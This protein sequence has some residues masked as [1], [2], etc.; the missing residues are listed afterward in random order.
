M[1]LQAEADLTGRFDFY[2]NALYIREQRLCVVSDIHIGLEE[3][4]YAD[5]L[6]FPLHEGETLLDRF[7]SILDRF[8]PRTVVLDGDIFH[9]FDRIARSVQRKFSMIVKTLS[10]ECEVIYVRGSHD[11]MLPSVMGGSVERYDAGG[12]TVIHGDKAVADHG[13]LVMGH[14]HPVVE[15]EMERFPCFLYGRG[16]VNGKDLLMM[17]AFNPLSPGVIINYAKGRDFLSPLLRRVDT[18]RLQPVVEVDGEAVVFPP[19]A[20]MRRLM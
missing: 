12:F 19:L 7:A 15:I 3:A 1:N 2:K 17:P 9:S 20:E 10:A 5:G 18:G 4:L 14:D 8:S 6:H 13:F 11:T 16:V